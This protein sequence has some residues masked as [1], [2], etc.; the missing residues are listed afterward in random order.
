MVQIS[1]TAPAETLLPF[2]EADPAASPEALRAAMNEQ[3]YLFFRHLVPEQDVIAVRRA[4][5]EQCD[6]AGWLD[7]SREL[8]DAVVAP[9]MQPTTENQTPYMAVYRKVLKLPS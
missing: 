6:A 2:A 4:V 8:L 5:L 3:G 9:D 1:A 7:R